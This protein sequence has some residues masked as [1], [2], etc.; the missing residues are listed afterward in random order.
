MNA[1]N[2]HTV[3]TVLFFV[4]FIGMVIWVYLPGRQSVYRDA[5]EL[6][7]DSKIDRNIKEK[8]EGEEK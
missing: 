6:P 5:A 3:L 4:V 8:Q 7:F 2:F 1:V